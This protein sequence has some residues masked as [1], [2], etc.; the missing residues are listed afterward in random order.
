M[1]ARQRYACKN[2]GLGVADSEL[3]LPE[4]MHMDKS[5]V[6]LRIVVHVRKYSHKIEFMNKFMSNKS[7]HLTVYDS[8]LYTKKQYTF[9]KCGCK[10]TVAHNDIL[11]YA[12]IMLFPIEA[13][14]SRSPVRGQNKE[15][16]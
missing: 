15:H 16:P 12:A 10:L 8:V 1:A 14:I 7:L 4:T 11:I 6:T 13:E 3:P 9:G 5:I 2:H